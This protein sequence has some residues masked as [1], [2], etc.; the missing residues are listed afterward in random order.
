MSCKNNK[1]GSDGSWPNDPYPGAWKGIT[2]FSVLAIGETLRHYGEHLAPKTRELWRE[3]LRR[4][5][6]FLFDSIDSRLRLSR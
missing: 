4:G 1:R 6:D 2:C 5:A 3:R